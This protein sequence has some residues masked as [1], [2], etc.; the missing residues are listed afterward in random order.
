MIRRSFQ[1]GHISKR[2]TQHG[3]VYDIRYRVRKAEGGWRQLC[4]TLH[5][6]GDGRAGRDKAEEI[7]RT[8]LREA[9]GAAG[10]ALPSGMTI[11]QFINTYWRQYLD[12]KAVK[13]S[14]R[15]SYQAYLNKHIMP[16]IGDLKLA[17]ISPFHI[18]ELVAKKRSE[19]LAARSVHHMYRLLDTIF[20]LAVDN[21]LVQ[22]SPVRKHHRPEYA[23]AS[24]VA[25]TPEQFRRLL[26][27]IPPAYQ[28]L[29]ATVALLGA[30]I[31]E[32]LGLQWKHVDFSSGEITISQSLWRGKLQTTKTENSA[33]I[34]PMSDFLLTTLLRHKRESVH[35]EPNNYVFCHMDGRPFDPDVLRCEVLY[36]AIER[37]GLPREN[38]SRGWHAFRR[39]ASTLIYRET[40][41]LKAARMYLG[42]A[43]EKTTELYT[44]VNRAS[45]ETARALEQA[46]FGDLLQT[47]TRTNSET[48]S[49]R[50][51]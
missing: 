48:Q 20:R 21:D 26:A 30:R 51:N 38:R 49:V 8:R 25:W 1:K 35:T 14:T 46:L 3:V 18:G 40:R 5:N 34:M 16:G 47:V 6:L 39:T 32:I 9:H 33:R 17:D 23:K 2:R 28:A 10:L 22:R 11:Q 45:P 50:P 7:L 37:A 44:H 12:R 31:G 24:K 41:D 42:H 13:P 43:G 15:A 27:Q 19:G 29:V 4:E 36:P